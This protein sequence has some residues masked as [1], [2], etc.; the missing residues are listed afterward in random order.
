MFDQFLDFHETVDDLFGSWRA[1]RDV[2][3]N[4]D[5]LVDALEHGV[6]IEDATTGGA[7]SDGYDPFGFCHLGID[8]LEYW[9]QLFGDRTC[10]QQDIG[11][12]GGETHALR[13]EAGQV[14]IGGHGGHKFYTAAGGGKGQGP[15]RIGAR[16]TDDF[17][18]VGGKEAFAGISGGSLDNLDV[19]SRFGYICAHISVVVSDFKLN[20]WF[21][22]VVQWYRLNLIP[23]QCAFL[24]DIDKSEQQGA[25]KQDHF[26]KSNGTQDFEIDGPG[27]HKDD[28]HIKQHEED[29]GEEVFD[30]KGDAGIAYA[31]DAAFKVDQFVTGLADGSC[32]MDH[33]QYQADKSGGYQELN[34][35]TDVIN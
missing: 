18:Q 19:G 16:Q 15:N 31:L 8:L 12:S 27:I 7:G 29:G 9:S 34:E 17:F 25:D 26:H 22:W 24:Y 30:G 21:G 14:I 10:H 2:D 23:F 4:G 3:I 35:Q 33:N 28:F 6:G 32:K 5:D 13:A 1:T 11:L 20:S